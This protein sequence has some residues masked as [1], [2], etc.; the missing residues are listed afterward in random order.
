MIC[1]G[2]GS[3]ETAARFR[4]EVNYGGELY[5]DPSRS[6]YKAMKLKK[7]SI[8]GYLDPTTFS[9]VNWAKV[10]FTPFHSHLDFA[11]HY[12]SMI[13]FLLHE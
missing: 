11:C 3:P 6:L 8:M 7:Q 1:I 5:V 9:V 13:S 12:L 4:K 2:N 10:L